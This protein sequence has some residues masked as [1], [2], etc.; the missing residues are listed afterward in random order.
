MNYFILLFAL[1]LVL[2]ISPSYGTRT[3]V[4]VYVKQSIDDQGRNDNV[5]M[6]TDIT[7]NGSGDD[8]AVT[9]TEPIPRDRIF[10]GTLGRLIANRSFS[11][12]STPQSVSIRVTEDDGSGVS[13]D[14]GVCSLV[15][16][17]PFI[18]GQ[19]VRVRCL[20]EFNDGLETAWNILAIVTYT[21][22]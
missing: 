3:R 2:A 10:A 6:V 12:I 22:S 19:D 21:A 13:K 14:D 4:R 1:F 5:E 15:I 18:I 11:T 20:R 16:E 9:A 8:R 17:A 7:R